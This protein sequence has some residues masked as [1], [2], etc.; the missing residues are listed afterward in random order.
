MGHPFEP[1]AWLANSMSKRDS[2]LRAGE[3]ILLGSLVTTK[4]L[5]KGDVVS[6]EIEGL[7]QAEARFA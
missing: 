6:V 3:F 4:W 2:F 7:G 1:L 5:D